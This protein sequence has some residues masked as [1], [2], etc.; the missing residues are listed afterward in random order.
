MKY[1]VC[2][3]GDVGVNVEPVAPLTIAYTP[4]PVFLYQ[5]YVKPVPVPP[6]ARDELM[7]AAG[8]PFSQTAELEDEMAPALI[9]VIVMAS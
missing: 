4:D 2:V 9:G 8:M 7:I 3:M 1:V 6:D 5:E